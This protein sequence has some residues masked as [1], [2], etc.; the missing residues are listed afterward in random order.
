MADAASGANLR[1]LSE[2]PGPE[3]IRWQPD[4]Q[5]IYFTSRLPKV[6]RRFRVDLRTGEHTEQPGFLRYIAFSPDGA[7][8]DRD[9]SGKRGIFKLNAS[10]SK[11]D[12]LMPL[13]EG[14]T[15]DA[16]LDPQGEWF[17]FTLPGSEPKPLYRLRADGS[18]KAHEQVLPEVLAHYFLPARGGLFYLQP[19]TAGSRLSSLML[20]RWTQ[21]GAAGKPI[22]LARVP[23]PLVRTTR[24]LTGPP[25]GSAVYF[26]VRVKDG[27]DLTLFEL[28]ARP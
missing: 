9:P 25:D 18:S 1:K 27:A 19:Q 15:Q 10:D 11:G 4:G 3:E 6:E 22:E 28:P 7:Y 23:S 21:R 24:F 2:Q 13:L 14:L 16:T 20:A 17:Y 12:S 8:I 26:S 5:A